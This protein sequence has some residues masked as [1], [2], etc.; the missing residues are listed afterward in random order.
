[1]KI[2]IAI[3]I[4]LNVHLAKSEQKELSTNLFYQSLSESKVQKEIEKIKYEK[5]LNNA[6]END[7]LDYKSNF[8]CKSKYFII[9]GIK[10]NHEKQCWEE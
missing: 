2:I 8:Y 3:I 10:V 7:W 9:N 1:M 5:A 6:I 4:F